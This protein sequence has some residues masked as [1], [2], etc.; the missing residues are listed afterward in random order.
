M[1]YSETFCHGVEVVHMTDYDA[2]Y[3]G[4]VVIAFV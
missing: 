1:S 3:D 4:G 2:N